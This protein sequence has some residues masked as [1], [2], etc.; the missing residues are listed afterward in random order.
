MS[1][2]KQKAKKGGD[3]QFEKAPPGNH[4]AV[5]VAIIDMGTQR[6]EYQGTET[7]QHRAFFVWELVTKKMSGTKGVNHLIG[8]DLTISL[9]EKAKLR[10]WIEARIGRQIPEGGEYDIDKELGQPCLLNVVEKNGYPKIEGVSQVPDGLTV[11]APQRPLFICTLDEF[12]SGAKVVPEWVPWLYGEPLPDHILRCVEIETGEVEC[13]VAS[14]P[15]QSRPAPQST[16]RWDYSDG[17]DIVTGK[18]TEEVRAFLATCDPAMIRVKPAGAPRDA[19]KPATEWPELAP[20][21]AEA[22]PDTIPF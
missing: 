2:W 4:P 12:A 3:G 5:C 11:P 22:E 16:Q 8:I 18:T 21:A 19:A 17:T 13:S 1:A 9:N 10:K 20:P 7:E 15:P 14:A 6:S